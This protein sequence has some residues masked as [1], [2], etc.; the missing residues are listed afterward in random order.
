MYGCPWSSG[1]TDVNASPYGIHSQPY[2]SVYTHCPGGVCCTGAL[3]CTWPWLGGGWVGAACAGAGAFAAACASPDGVE[4]SS[5]AGAGGPP[6]VGPS[7]V[8]GAPCAGAF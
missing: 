8:S 2:C 4:S 7:A 6:S 3:P 5:A 1:G